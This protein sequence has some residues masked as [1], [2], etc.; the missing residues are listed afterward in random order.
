MQASGADEICRGQLAEKSFQ[1]KT[2]T[3]DRWENGK[4]IKTVQGK[5][6]ER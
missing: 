5:D 1:R 3:F 4:L 6:K 2:G